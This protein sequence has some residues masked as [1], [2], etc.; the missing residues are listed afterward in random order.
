MDIGSA[1]LE[2]RNIPPMLLIKTEGN[3]AAK[4]DEGYW[5]EGHDLVYDFDAVAGGNSHNI[6]FTYNKNKYEKNPGA[7]PS[8][9]ICPGVFNVYPFGDSSGGSTYGN[10]CRAMLHV[11]Y[12]GQY[13][14]VTSTKEDV[15]G[16]PAGTIISNVDITF[17][18]IDD[19]APDSANVLH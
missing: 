13:K 12:L 10:D 2:N 15:G 16:F 1:S 19:F 4:R 14:D 5:Q 18:E 11:K 6:E 3:C 7:D 8:I 9:V 17:T